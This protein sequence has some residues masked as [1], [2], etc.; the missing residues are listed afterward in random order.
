MNKVYSIIWNAALGIWV[1]VSELTRGK[2]KSSSRKTVAV[3]AASALSGAT[4]MASAAQITA[5]GERNISDDFQ[6]GISAGVYQAPH[7]YG[8]L[9]ENNTA[10]QTLNISGAIPTINPGQSGVVESTTISELLRTG[11]ITLQATSPGQDAKKSPQL[12]SW[13]NT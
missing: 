8:F 12:K 1:V 4:M 10:S 2:K 11:K 7:D 5:T 9:Y 3:L 6:N 13:R